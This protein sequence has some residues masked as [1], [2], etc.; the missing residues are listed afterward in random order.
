MM[1]IKGTISFGAAMAGLCSNAGLGLLVLIR[2][3]SSLKD[4][5]LVISLL[6]LISI[7]CGIVL[8]FLWR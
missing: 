7:L 8:Q 1:L 5:A 4:T 6:L 3:N 2:K